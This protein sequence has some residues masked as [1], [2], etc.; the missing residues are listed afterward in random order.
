MSPKEMDK[1]SRI[2]TL[3]AFLGFTIPKFFGIIVKLPF[4]YLHTV[5]TSIVYIAKGTWLLMTR[6]HDKFIT[7][8]KEYEK[9]I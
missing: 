4:L 3:T 8:L 2:V 7:F 5:A 6:K 1:V 9:K